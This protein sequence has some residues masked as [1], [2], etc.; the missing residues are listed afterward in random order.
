MAGGQGEAGGDASLAGGAGRERAAGGGEPTMPG[1]G[2]DRAADAASSGEALVGRVDD[3]V[4]GLGDDVAPDKLQGG[5]ADGVAG[6]RW[7]PG[8]S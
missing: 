8:R 5:G 2:E 4:G 3:S 1:G 6:H 7:F